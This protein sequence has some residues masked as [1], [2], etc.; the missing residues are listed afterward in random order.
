MTIHYSKRFEKSFSKLPKIIKLKALKKEHL[1]LAD[2][3]YPILK[4]HKLHGKQKEEWSYSVD[5]SYRIT[6]IFL[7][8]SSILYLDI[9][10]H[11]QLYE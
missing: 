10:T 9:G 7:P 2:P 8:D 6:F 5:S 11:D 4:T 3:F 1:F